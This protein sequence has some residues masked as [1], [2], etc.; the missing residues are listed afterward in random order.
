[1][2]EEIEKTKEKKEENA[3]DGDREGKEMK[4]MQVCVKLGKEKKGKTTDGME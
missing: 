3:R 4:R 1:M 2:D